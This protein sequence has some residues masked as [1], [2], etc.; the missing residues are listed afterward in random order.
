LCRWSWAKKPL[1]FKLLNHGYDGD[2]YTILHSTN[3]IDWD[4]QWIFAL[5]YSNL[6]LSIVI[7]ILNRNYVT[8]MHIFSHVFTI[9]E[10][11]LPGK[12][13]MFI[14]FMDEYYYNGTQN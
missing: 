12:H 10:Y 8:N 5:S 4:Q 7:Q 6:N 14:E 3:T 11:I 9:L 2:N 13:P 1:L